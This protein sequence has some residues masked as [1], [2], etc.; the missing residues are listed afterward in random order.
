MFIQPIPAADNEPFLKADT[1]EITDNF[2]FFLFFVSAQ[3]R[4]VFGSS[5]KICVVS[6][7]NTHTGDDMAFFR[8]RNTR[9]TLWKGAI[10]FYPKP[11]CFPKRNQASLFLSARLTAERTLLLNLNLDPESAFI[12][13]KLSSGARSRKLSTVLAYGKKS[14]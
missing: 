11:W 3:V 8:Y 12:L 10:F 13:W 2:H 6:E 9:Q 14:W 1:D 5:G 4:L 7:H